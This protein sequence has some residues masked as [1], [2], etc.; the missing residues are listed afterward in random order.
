MSLCCVAMSQGQ[1][2]CCYRPFDSN[3]G[4]ALAKL[5]AEVRLT[6]L[7]QLATAGL[8]YTRPSGGVC[9]LLGLGKSHY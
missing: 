6:K 3:K 7:V 1:G 2:K 4:V 9:L 5:P 8:L